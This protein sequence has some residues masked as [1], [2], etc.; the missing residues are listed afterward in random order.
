MSLD[1]APDAAAGITS[2]VVDLASVRRVLKLLILAVQ[3]L[4]KTRT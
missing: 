4:A 2:D 3:L 1:R